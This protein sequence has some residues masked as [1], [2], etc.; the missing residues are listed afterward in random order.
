[1]LR[2]AHYMG[3]VENPMKENKTPTNIMLRPS[4]RKWAEGHMKAKGA[5][6]LSELIEVLML[7]EQRRAH[8][9]KRKMEAKC[10]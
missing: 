7:K 10:A 8:D 3:N 4:L 5:S 1:M 2:A 6:S 9:N